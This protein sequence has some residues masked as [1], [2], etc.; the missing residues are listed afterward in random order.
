VVADYRSQEVA[1]ADFRQ[2]KGPKVVSFSPMSH[3]T[4]QKIRV[5][6]FIV[7]SPWLWPG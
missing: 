5:T 1:E 7:C 4:D 6:S 2:M 3:W